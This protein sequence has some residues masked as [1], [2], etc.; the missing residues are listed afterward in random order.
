[1]PK[2][3]TLKKINLIGKENYPHDG[4]PKLTAKEVAGSVHFKPFKKRKK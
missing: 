2:K 4:F 3:K 1:M